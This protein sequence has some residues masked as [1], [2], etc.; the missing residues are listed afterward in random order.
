M[1]EERWGLL[2]ENAYS[3]REMVIHRDGCLLRCIFRCH[4][5]CSWGSNFIH[6]GFPVLEVDTKGKE[7]QDQNQQSWENE[8]IQSP[9]QESCFL[10][11]RRW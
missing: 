3:S 9:P 1:R 6:K 7:G 8:H 10:M 2:D 4:R 5:R 11:G